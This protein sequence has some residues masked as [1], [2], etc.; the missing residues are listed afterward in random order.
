M[1]QKQYA[2]K[3]TPPNLRP[4]TPCS[5]LSK[6]VLDGMQG[7]G[8]AHRLFHIH[9]IAMEKFNCQCMTP[10]LPSSPRLRWAWLKDIMLP[11]ALVSMS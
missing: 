2:P 7:A 8:R 11:A 6:C 9:Y 10:H 1:V 3:M 4:M 5:V